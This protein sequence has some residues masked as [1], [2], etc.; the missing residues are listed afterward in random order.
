VL[1]AEHGEPDPDIGHDILLPAL[2]IKIL[3]SGGIDRN[4]NGV[5][6]TSSDLNNDGVISGAEILP[7]ADADG[8]FIIDQSEIQDERIVWAVR[9]GPDFGIGG[10]CCIDPDGN[11]WVGLAEVDYYYKVDG[12]T[13]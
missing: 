5:I 12:N 11:V 1:N 7:L 8:D 13:G 4:G 9:V 3:A 10:S 2:L 6:D